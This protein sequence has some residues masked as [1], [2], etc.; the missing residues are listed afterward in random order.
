[1][2]QQILIVEDEADIRELLRF[3]LEREGFTVHEGAPWRMQ[4]TRKRQ[5]DSQT[6]CF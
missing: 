6:G 5:V 3:N 1:M 4:R 2:S